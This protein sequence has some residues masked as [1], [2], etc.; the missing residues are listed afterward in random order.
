MSEIPVDGARLNRL[1]REASPYLL[2]HQANPVDWYPW[3]EE[4]FALSR[5]EQRPIFLSV[6]YSTCYWCHVMERE[7]FADSATAELMNRLFVNIKVDREE[8]P[9]IDEIY[10]AATQLITQQ[11]GWPNSVFL[12]PELKPFYAG[13]YFPP[14]PRQGMPSF[15]QL[16]GGLADAWQ[17]RRDEVLQQAEQIAEGMRQFLED[18]GQPEEQPPPAAVAEQSFAALT[19]RFDERFG[20]FGGAPKFPTPAN[21]FLLLE[22]AGE[23]LDA[24]RML[25]TTLD[26]MARGGIYDQLAGGF[27]RYSVDR[28]WLVPHFEKMLYDNGQ[29]L[30][31]YAREFGRS[32]DLEAARIVRE[33]AHFIAAE[34]GAPEGGFWSAIDAEIDG[35]E[36][37]HHVWAEAELRELLGAEGFAFLAPLYGFEGPPSFE[38]QHYVLHLLAPLAAQAERRQ[39]SYSA[40]LEQIEPLKQRL[41]QARR[42]R[43]MPL[44]DDKVLTDW[45]GMAITGLALAGELLGEPALV[46]RAALA[47]EFVLREL[48][49]GDGTLLHAWRQGQAKIEA[50]LADYVHLVRGLLALA[51]ATGEGAWRRHAEQLTRQQIERLGDPV[52]GF[53][54]AGERPDVLF[55][56]KEVF[57]GA[58]PS[59]NALAVLNLVELAATA[60]ADQRGEW[61]GEAESALKALA[62]FTRKQP[63]AARMLSIAARRFAR[64]E[65]SSLAMAELAS[66]PAETAPKAVIE[67]LHPV[68][69]QSLVSALIQSGKPGGDGWRSFAVEVE[70]EAGWHIYANPSGDDRLEPATLRGEGAEL[71]ALR[72]PS[73]HQAEEGGPRVYDGQIEI[74]GR[75]RPGSGSWALLLEFQPCDSRR[76]LAITSLRLRG[77]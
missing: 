10:M 60:P 27:H 26:R 68:N 76:C 9:E 19:Q 36:G 37:A 49:R 51:S 57:D 11:G 48:R 34:L 56:S 25:T 59:A 61:L 67:E 32:G 65:A 77:R 53:Y 16:I 46:D 62:M 31:V 8:R 75:L 44:V 39:V 14:S 74:T 20:G 24:A 43:Q 4:A 58:L 33:T 41:L 73:G 55:R 13:T 7:S 6:G 72:Y 17:S 28:E 35:H 52:G 21:L 66:L 71:E 12:T 38:G 3:G 45:N 2:L 5:R 63:D 23:Q 15:Q 54:T 70:V 30:E 42:E 69:P 22:L 29:L 47:A 18:R 40:L 1:A 50:Y 64:L